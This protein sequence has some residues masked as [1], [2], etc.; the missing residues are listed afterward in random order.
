MAHNK[1]WKHQ[2]EQEQQQ[3]R[4]EEQQDKNVQRVRIMFGTLYTC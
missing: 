1:C 2:H 4:Q 3:E